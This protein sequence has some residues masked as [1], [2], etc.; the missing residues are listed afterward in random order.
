VVWFSNYTVGKGKNQKRHKKRHIEDEEPPG[1][2]PRAGPKNQFDW[3]RMR[4]CGG[5]KY[6][7]PRNSL[8]KGER[9]AK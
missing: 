3:T 7:C 9:I 6:V 2:Y 5:G 1:Q 8:R 4:R